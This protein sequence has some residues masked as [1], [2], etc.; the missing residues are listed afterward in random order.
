MVGNREGV[1]PRR[2]VAE[3]R[4]RRDSG[5]GGILPLIGEGALSARDI[6]RGRTSGSP[7]TGHMRHAANRN[8]QV[9]HR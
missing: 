5:I 4:G 2:A 3:R 7:E 6:G 8:R 9:V 1:S